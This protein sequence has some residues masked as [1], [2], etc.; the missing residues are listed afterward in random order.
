[1][2]HFHAI[3]LFGSPIYTLTKATTLGTKG[4]VRKNFSFFLLYI[5]SITPH[6]S[7]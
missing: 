3:S 1:M 2:A 5:S 7:A 6:H 4:E